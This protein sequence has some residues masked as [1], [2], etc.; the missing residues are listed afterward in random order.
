MREVVKEVFYNMNSIRDEYVIKCGNAGMK[1]SLIRFWMESQLIILYPI[2][3]HFCDIMWKSLFIEKI[4]KSDN[5]PELVSLS[6]YPN[7]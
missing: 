5:L 1:K 4:A 3:P 2:T 6:S 7:I